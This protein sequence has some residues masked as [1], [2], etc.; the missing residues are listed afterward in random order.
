L[1]ILSLKKTIFKVSTEKLRQISKREGIMHQQQH[2]ITNYQRIAR[3]LAK[4]HIHRLFEPDCLS[5][6]PELN[7]RTDIKILD[8]G[9]RNGRLL[10]RLAPFMDTCQL[11]GIDIN[12]RHIQRN[13]ARNKHQNL[14][15]HCSPAENLPFENDYFDMVICSNALRHF[16]Q[17]V[18]ALDEMYRV[19]KSGGDLYLLEGIRDDKWK[20]RF[21]KILRQ[22]KFIRPE[23]KYLP[24]TALLSKSYFIHY[25]K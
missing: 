13:Q 8:V 20:Q 25:V 7:L 16:P 1:L 21:E 12:A 19:L 15:F 22:S 23:K 11:H 3:L 17:R 10:F 6:L 9:C 18:R 2:Q 14:D 4:N 24:R 5:I